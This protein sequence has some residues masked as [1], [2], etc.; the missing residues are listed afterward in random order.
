[1]KYRVAVGVES[2]PALLLAAGVFAVAVSQ[3]DRWRTRNPSPEMEVLL[4]PFAQVTMAWGDPY[5]AA[6]IGGIRALVA[7][8]GRMTKENYRVLAAVQ[9]DVARFN[10]AH[11][12]NYYIGA[13]ILPWN[14]ELLAAQYVLH[15][16]IDSRPFDLWP[17]FFYGF[18]THHFERNSLEGARWLRVAAQRTQDEQ[19]HFQLEEMAARWIQLGA[20]PKTA[21]DM[22]RAMAKGARNNAFAMHLERMAMRIDNLAAINRAAAAFLARN[23]RKA[24]RFEELLSGDRMTGLKPDPF[25]GRY[26]LNADGTAAVVEKEMR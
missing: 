4:P 14:G 24:T 21:A 19:E 10:P 25:G 5:L 12:D 22:L 26:G 7:E 13:A 6:N 15:R 9:R 23:G 17:P 11:E 1:M 20:D 2:W 8:T 3:L 16:A 18:N